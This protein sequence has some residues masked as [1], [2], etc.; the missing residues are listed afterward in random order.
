MISSDS[1]LDFKFDTLKNGR[2]EFSTRALLAEL[3]SK[4]TESERQVF[5]RQYG[6]S[7]K[8]PHLFETL[9]FDRHLQIPVD[10]AHCICQGLDKVLLETTIALM[11][12]SGRDK[13]STLIRQLE[14]PRGW[15]RFQDPVYH[16]KSYFFCDLARLI[17][18]GPLILV[19][20]SEEDFIK[21]SLQS[22]KV[23]LGLNSLSQVRHQ[24]LECWVKLASTSAIVFASEISSYE[25]LDKNIIAL[26]KQLA[27]VSFLSFIFII[28]T[29]Y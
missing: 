11:S 2:Y 17:M 4:P 10:P 18:I 12:G 15:P 27:T 3:S 6:L 7:T 22:L 29:L 28:M 19:Q 25:D 8:A 13:F 1:W 21:P 20:L 26:A 16:F 9:V 23:N 5:A 24:I 14:L